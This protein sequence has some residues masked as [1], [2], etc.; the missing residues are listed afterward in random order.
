LLWLFD[1]KTRLVILGSTVYFPLFGLVELVFN[2]VFR[3]VKFG[4]YSA[5]FKDMSYK[6]PMLVIF[7]LSIS[8][9]KFL[10]L[11]L[12]LPFDLLLYFLPLMSSLSSTFKVNSQSSLLEVNSQS[13][14]WFLEV[15]SQSPL[16]LLKVISHSFLT[17][18]K[19]KPQSYLIVLLPLLRIMLIFV[20]DLYLQVEIYL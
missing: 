3:F 4:D 16:L 9:F 19:V 5:A 10:Q 15:N 20:F 12:S 2:I 14:L 18:L 1:S 8:L 17:V 11:K 6:A 7:L 13:S